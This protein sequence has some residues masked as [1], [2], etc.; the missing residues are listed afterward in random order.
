MKKLKISLAGILAL[1]LF[2]FAYTAYTQAATIR[3]PDNFSTIQAALDAARSGDTVIVAK[4]V[5]KGAG[6]K[7][8]DFKGKA[9]TLESESGPTQTIIDCEGMGRGFYF[10]SRETKDAVLKGFTIKN[11][12]PGGSLVQ[13]A[14]NTQTGSKLVFV[15]VQSDLIRPKNDGDPA[16]E[17]GELMGL[18]IVLK[19]NSINLINN[20]VATLK[21]TD[22]RVVGMTPVYTGT[23]ITSWNEVNM[24]SVGIPVTYGTIYGN[25]TKSLFYQY[26]KIN[27]N[28]MPLGDSVKFTLEI[29]ADNSLVGTDEFL[30]K[31][32]ADIILDT[33][34]VDEY[35]KPD[36]VPGDIELRIRNITTNLLENIR[37]D[38]STDSRRVNFDNR[39]VDITDMSSGRTRTVAFKTTIDSGFSGHVKLTLRIEVNRVLVNIENFSYYFGMRSQYI[40]HWIVDDDNRNGIAEPGESIELQISRWNPTN[41][42]AKNVRATLSTSD[43]RI[44]KIDE[45]RGDY[46][47]ILAYDVK[48]SR[49]EYDFT[50]ADASAFADVTDFDLRG[51]TVT[52]KLAVEED[53]ILMGEETFTMRIGGTI[54][55]LPSDGYEYLM[56]TI[57]DSKSLS[58]SNNANGIPEPGETIGIQITL[59]NIW[60]DHID[61]VEAELRSKNDVSFIVDYKNYGEIRRRN[62]TRTEE[63]LVKIDEVFEGN[64]IVFEIEIEGRIDGSR[65][66]FGMDV[67]TIP[68]QNESLN[69]VF[70]Y[71]SGTVLIDGGVTTTTTSAST[72]G[73]GGAISCVNA[74][75][76]TIKNNIITRNT[77]TSSGGGIFCGDGASPLIVN[78]VISG[79]SA[80]AFGGGISCNNVSSPTLINNTIYGNTAGMQGGG[81]RAQNSSFPT[82]LNT[83]L[84]ANNPNQ[85]Y[86][87]SGS[88]IGITYSDVQGGWIGAG[89]INAHPLFVD[90]ANDDYRLMDNSPCIA[91]G[92]V[93]ANMP[94]KD[95]EDKLRPSPPG[96][97]PDIGAY[98]SQMPT[99]PLTIKDVAPS[100]GIQGTNGL[101]ITINGS[102]FI[103]GATVSF[104]GSGIIVV[105]TSFVNS[106]KLNAKINISTGAPTGARNVIVTNPGGLMAIGTNMFQVNPAAAVALK[107]DTVQTTSRDSNFLA[108]VKV[109][110]IIDLAGFQMEIEFSPAIFEVIKIEE[111]A[112][113]KTGASTF[114][115]EPIINKTTGTITQIASARLSAGGVSGI[116]VL[117]R[118]TLRAKA[119]GEGFIKFKNAILSDSR[120]SLIS[121]STYDANVKVSGTPPWDVN[122]D[123]RVD[124]LD[125]VLVAQSIGDSSPSGTGARYDVNGDGVVNV[126]DLVLV[127]QHFGE[128]YTT[129]AAP[130]A[131]LKA[132]PNQLPA[133]VKAYNLMEENPSSDPA[134]IRAKE[135]LHSLISD[136]KANKTAMFQNYPNPFNPE[137]W[138]PYQLSEGSEVEI[139]IYNSAGQL[140][141]T[142]DMGYRNP[143]YYIS[144]ADAAFWD[145]IDGNG[146]KVS[147][148]V[149][150]YIVRAGQYSETRKMLMVK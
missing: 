100:S 6:N 60:T 149:Y 91:A 109:E 107:I 54:R 42:T 103:D 117:A 59:I 106:T 95:I 72:D 110:G 137:T 40:N 57:S 127:S 48:E 129:S 113:L 119:N 120:G 25:S 9:I 36:G 105:S 82:V 150:F 10:H 32:G 85:I 81:I 44:I 142:L 17:P 75:S 12:S 86:I 80:S 94:D 99:L 139:K 18:D 67:F 138:I 70:N 13:I 68:V 47:D 115:Q 98:E 24:S 146:E 62:S 123:G 88:S 104:S 89:N 71:S 76:P 65:R 122:G 148:G 66:K 37:L 133:L 92:I 61:N 19:N 16:V 31:V 2:L 38:I 43:T 5:Y 3:V 125:L 77:A 56:R 136:I 29:R 73:F 130:G 28:F 15:D 147:S 50:I 23:Q 52:F 22:T 96:S 83:I 55:Y 140:I 128:V 39:R 141:R 30:V 112:F 26:V 144:K 4:G 101:D 8:L 118:I 78:N 41:Q 33:V 58:P 132:T 84:W 116:G 49:Y 51:H 69:S 20:V 145:G 63:F 35:L 46:R 87:D 53:G 34:D 27:N 131:V 108:D 102:N 74:S 134:F 45:D 14:L 64:K 124:I 7:N 97:K 90:T 11:G 121:V 111:G 135:L 79:N 93:A 114:W 126:L 1:L 143:G 21:T